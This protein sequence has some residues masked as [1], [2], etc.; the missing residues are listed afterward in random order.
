MGLALA[1]Q[2]DDQPDAA[3][4]GTATSRADLTP[5]EQVAEAQRILDRGTALSRRVAAM[6]DEAR[7][8]RDV[9]RATCLD[10]K[11]TQINAHLRTLTSRVEALRE[12]VRLGD[13]GRRNHE[14]T[15]CSVLNQHFAELERE[16]NECIGQDIFE[17]RPTQ[18]VTII[19]PTVPNVDPGQT[20][21][22]G[23]AFPWGI[24]PPSFSE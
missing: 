14:F 11:L 22:L 3:I 2:P 6:L 19:D 4:E 9:I 10:D 7:R 23:P 20:P 1:Q 8:Q 12:A 16:A 13:E 18:I 21:S 5:E 24:F 15:V 17:T